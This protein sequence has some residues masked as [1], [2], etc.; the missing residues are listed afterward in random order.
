MIYLFTAPV[1]TGKT[2][3]LMAWAKA[4]KDV[5]GFFSPDVGELR[6]LCR[7]RSVEIHEP[8]E[9]KNPEGHEI[10]SIGKFHF[11]DAAFAKAMEWTKEDLENPDIQYLI[12]DEI[13]KLEL[14]E[15]GFHAL[16]RSVQ[17]VTDKHFILIV[18]SDRL[19]EI[20]E[21]YNLNEATIVLPE[22]LFKIS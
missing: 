10:Q 4:R 19:A 2:T 3:Q 20:I 5:G 14:K 15:K 6:V 7:P 21:F 13:S 9:I 22:E 8:F 12:F 17:K 18:R 11:L 16:M 1:R